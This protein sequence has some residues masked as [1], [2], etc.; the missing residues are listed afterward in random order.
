MIHINEHRIGNYI[1]VDA[2]MQKICFISTD[3]GF[4]G[5]P[6]I[7]YK[8]GGKLKYEKSDSQRLEA[9]PLTDTLLKSFGFIFHDHFKLWQQK[10]SGNQYT[11]ELDRDY[12]AMDFF[13][14]P[15][16]KNMQYLHALQNLY[17]SIHGEELVSN[18]PAGIVSS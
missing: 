12:T 4:A 1:L 3:P 8:Q 5:A 11:I 7:G 17:F 2:E 14:R 10:N 6:G 9:V 15:M 16:I 13:H 18:A